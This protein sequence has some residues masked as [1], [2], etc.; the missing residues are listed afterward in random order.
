VVA[1]RRNLRA[2][3]PVV[4]NVPKVAWPPL[5][6]PLSSFVGR[7]AEIEELGR[8]LASTRLLTLTGAGGCGKTRLAIELATRYRDTF[9]DGVALVDVAPLRDPVAVPELIAALGLAEQTA[10]EAAK[11]IADARVLI[12][13]D[14]AEHLVESAS[15]VAEELLAAC[16]NLCILVT[17][18]EILD[19][20]GEVSWRVPPLRLPPRATP[21]CP[22]DMELLAAS[23]AVRLFVARA[24]EHHTVFQLTDDNAHLVDTICRRLDG[25]P[26]A[27]ELAAARVRS[28]TLREIV[29]RLDDSFRLLTHGTRTAI[30]RHRTLRAM[31]DWSYEMLS[32]REELLLGRLA[33]FVGTADLE[34]IEAVCARPDLPVDEIPDMLHLLID[35]SLVSLHARPDGGLRYGLMEVIRQYALERLSEASELTIQARHA[36]YFGDLARRFASVSFKNRK[37]LMAAEYDNVR[38]AMDWADQHDAQLAADMVDRMRW[39]WRTRGSIGEALRRCLSVLAK[40]ASAPSAAVFGPNTRAGVHLNVAVW[41]RLAGN[42]KAAAAQVDVAASLLDRVDDPKLAFWIMDLQGVVRG[43]VGDPVGAEGSIRRAVDMLDRWPPDGDPGDALHIRSIA[44]NDLA[45]ARLMCGQ[46]MDALR[47]IQNALRLVGQL[48]DWENPAQA[49]HLLHT[50]GAVLLALGR[51]ADARAQFLDGLER[52]AE[53]GNDKGAVENLWALACIAAAAGQPE[54][55]LELVAAGHAWCRMAGLGRES[56]SSAEEVAEAERISRLAIGER[57]AEEVWARGLRMD[58]GAA[59]ERARGGDRTPPEL[60]LTPRKA[61]IVRMV[62]DGLFNKEIA[63]RLSISERT[64]ESHLDQIRSL[65][66]LH[67]RAQVAAWAVSKGLYS[68]PTDQT[69]IG[70]AT[71]A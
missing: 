64:V 47:D 57:A 69:G 27:L 70:S 48:P 51:V 23:D 21:E 62:A 7:R 5:P 1:D 44:L 2:G 12:I 14:N 31:V 15:T 18:R 68:A 55:C 52:A 16:A 36:Y 60:S 42:L 39:F 56:M 71:H 61:Q 37:E 43:Q 34:A 26:L 32:D 59:L 66:G 65:L 17:S 19:I 45:M 46:T 38:L 41:L 4:S 40:L 11:V 3:E 25:I 58:L 20:G 63:R 8:M 6:K 50:H 13:I 35:K 67:N 10:I 28:M 30:P 54:R 49:A 29:T 33:A 9:P 24:A 22:I 53:C